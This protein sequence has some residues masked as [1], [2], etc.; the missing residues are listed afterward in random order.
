[1]QV[2]TP[3]HDGDII[4]L[5]KGVAGVRLLMLIPKNP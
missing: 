1:M 2:R 3:V 4:E 5:A